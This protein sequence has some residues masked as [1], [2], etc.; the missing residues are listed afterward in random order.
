[1]D[2]QKLSDRELLLKIYEN[3]EKTR[4][5]IMWGRI[6]G[7]IY[8]IILVAPIIIAM[9]YLPPLIEKSMAPLNDILSTTPAERGS[10]VIKELKSGDLDLQQILD[11]YTGNR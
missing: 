11:S 5:Y 10:D 2:L 4:K 9:I 8:I 7:L 1:M 3:T 6:M